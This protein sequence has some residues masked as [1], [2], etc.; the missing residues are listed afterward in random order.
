MSETHRDLG[1]R[2]SVCAMPTPEM[3]DLDGAP[4]AGAETTTMESKSTWSSTSSAETE[5]D[6]FWHDSSLSNH[7]Y[8]TQDT[9][10]D[11]FNFNDDSLFFGPFDSC[12]NSLV[13]SRDQPVGH[14]IQTPTAGVD[15]I[16]F[17][18]PSQLDL[19][20]P[21]ELL[22]AATDLD[23]VL[24]EGDLSWTMMGPEDGPGQSLR[25]KINNALVRGHDGCLFMPEDTLRTVLS[26]HA[27]HTELISQFPHLP[28]Q[29]VQKMATSITASRQ[30]LRLLRVFGLLVLLGKVESIT[31]FLAKDHL[32]LPLVDFTDPCLNNWTQTDIEALE[33]TQWRFISP[34]FT[35]VTKQQ[36]DY[37]DLGEKTILPFIESWE[38]KKQNHYKGGNSEVWKVKI[39]DAHHNFK[40]LQTA[41]PYF[42]IKKLKS[43]DE[44]AFHREVRNLQRLHN[45]DH[46]N[47]LS[48]LATYKYKGSYHLV[49]PWAESDLRRLWQS[50]ENPQQPGKEDMRWLA[51]QC[52]SIA[53]ALKS[54]HAGA[55]S[56][57]KTTDDPAGQ[58]RLM[59]KI[60]IHGDI[61]P[62]NIFIFSKG[63]K[64]KELAM[65]PPTTGKGSSIPSDRSSRSESP[66]SV[67]DDRDLVIGDFGGGDFYDAS[68]NPDPLRQM[69]VTYRPPEYDTKL[70]PVSR[71]WDVWGLGCTYLEFVTWFLLGR[72]GLKEFAKRR[73]TRTASGKLSDEY[74]DTF[75]DPS[76]TGGVGAILK[77]SVL[78]WINDLS[79]HKN[80]SPFIRDFLNFITHRMFIIEDAIVNR[81]SGDEVAYHMNTLNE[82][83]R[84]DD[85]YCAPLPLASS[86]W[87]VESS[88]SGV[89]TLSST[90]PDDFTLDFTTTENISGAS[91][92]AWNFSMDLNPLQ[93]NTAPILPASGLASYNSLDCAD[94]LGTWNYT[95]PVMWNNEEFSQASASVEN[96][97]KRKVNEEAGGFERR[98]SPKTSTSPQ[99]SGSSTAE[100]SPAA[101]IMKAGEKRFAC[102]YWWPT[103]HRVKEHLYRCHTIGKH[104][105]SRCL[106]KCKSASE[107]LAHQR[108]SIPCETKTD[109]FPEGTMMPSQEEALRIKKRV[110]PNTTE[111][112]RWNEV[113]LILF[114]GETGA[115][116]S[117]FYEDE[118]TE[119]R[120]PES[121]KQPE[122]S[123]SWLCSPSEYERYLSQSLPPRV[124][125]ELEREVQRE[126]GFVGDAAQTRKVVDM[127]QKLQLRL[128]RQFES[129]RAA[130]SSSSKH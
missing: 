13:P 9:T 77:G 17:A 1:T 68:K 115:L 123:D 103:V 118:Q 59:N 42:A 87:E 79:R 38:N 106:K 4:I 56:W 94:V 31:V 78:A 99:E 40:N 2:P 16:D 11:T 49:F 53:D 114:P 55:E 126:F 51:N 116:P 75:V 10:L 127:V 19:G 35:N 71:S 86:P 111:E 105:C 89:T 117:P 5:L 90:S 62:E 61:K 125:R 6:N 67:A 54:V 7:F 28:A 44:E 60:G 101:N 22:P 82:K 27:V 95:A 18:N 73:T 107:L 122:T 8:T 21:Q 80:A 108:T 76:Q 3:S 47:L 43:K 26:Q 23:K 48:L 100:E 14:E 58:Q 81:A 20:F 64:T 25:D 109:A 52:A 98:V 33:R 50:T 15:S 65:G 70:K 130:P 36:D 91:N 41:T 112:Q 120:L 102:P 85:S 24:T 46:P 124:Q 83:C 32:T 12:S 37:V 104:T 128:F 96:R 97:R 84:Q 121:A 93:W 45:A 30:G 119:T 34:V 113:Y 69:T 110:P 88:D 72:A 74:F 57:L 39:H 29:D 63:Q 92:S 66:S 129:E